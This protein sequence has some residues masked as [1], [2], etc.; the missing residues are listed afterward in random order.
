MKRDKGRERRDREQK[1]REERAHL[2]TREEERDQETHREN[3]AM[4]GLICLA[5]GLFLAVGDTSYWV[6]AKQILSQKILQ[7][8]VESAQHQPLA[9]C[10]LT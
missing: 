7:R 6:L 9:L 5:L 2:G 10:T 1:D 8:V 3:V 4:R